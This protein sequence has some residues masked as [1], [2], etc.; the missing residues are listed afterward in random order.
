MTARQAILGGVG[1]SLA[2]LVAGCGGGS[3]SS[4]PTATGPIAQPV[5]PGTVLQV[6]Q[7]TPNGLATL[8]PNGDGSYSVTDLQSVMINAQT[9]QGLGQSV[10]W[11]L[12]AVN[13]NGVSYTALASGGYGVPDATDPIL[14]LVGYSGL[15]SV[16]SSV[17]NPTGSIPLQF[18]PLIGPGGSL[19]VGLSQGLTTASAGFSTNVVFRVLSAYAG[20]WSVSYQS[21]TVGSSGNPAYSGTCAIGVSNA[22]VVSGSCTDA[23]LGTYPVTGRDYGTGNAYGVAFEGRGVISFFNGTSPVAA[24]LL[25]G[26]TN[27]FVTSSSSS[28]STAG[29]GT[30]SGTTTT[31]DVTSIMAQD[32]VACDLIPGA[33]FV[34]VANTQTC[35]STN[36]LLFG[37]SSSSTSTGATTTTSGGSTGTAVP[38][39]WTAIKTS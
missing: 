26:K 22:G 27:L 25:Q 18:A 31:S 2:M 20:T 7:S 29:T 3:G 19:V 5:L 13:Q 11:G 32:P 39:T 12:S 35:S 6:L 28:S 10:Y 1:A 4:T 34:Q 9:T 14:R 8:P 38:V 23:Q 17:T 37:S 30:T 33:T 15:A 21:A 36:S 16:P 24:N